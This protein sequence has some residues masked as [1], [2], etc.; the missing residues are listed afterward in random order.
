MAKNVA[1]ITLGCAKNTVDSEVAK[2]LLTSHGYNCEARIEDADIII[3]NTCGFIKD[4]KEQSIETIFSVLA[5]KKK[6]QKI[7][8]LGCLAQRYHRELQSEI[9]ELDAVIGIA[10]ES[11]LHE[12]IEKLT[13]MGSVAEVKD[14]SSFTKEIF[15]PRERIDITYHTYLKIAEGCNNHC[16]YCIIPSIRGKYRSKLPNDIVYEARYL[17]KKG[18]KEVILIAQDIGCY[19]Q[20]LHIKGGLVSLLKDLVEIEDL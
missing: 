20:D 10:Q 16:T 18:Y 13:Q 6:H 3:I 4:A 17:V 12:F 8:V 19:G 5:S 9:P 15:L 1:F 11:N 2:G 14:V 7:A